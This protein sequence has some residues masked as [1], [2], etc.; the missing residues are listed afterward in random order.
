[1]KILERF[2]NTVNRATLFIAAVLFIIMLSCSIL[3]V[4]FRYFLNMSLAWTEECARYLF[5]YVVLLGSSV[6]V[7]ND[8]HVIVDLLVSK[9]TGTAKNVAKGFS[10][11]CMI[12]FFMATIRYGLQAMSRAA[13]QVSPVTR[14]NL[15]IVYFALPLSSFLMLIYSIEGLL[16]QILRNVPDDNEIE[17]EKGAVK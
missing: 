16:K 4:I 9:L 6:L 7:K 2:N 10:Y 14:T 1:M 15:G 3:Q 17:I 13:L 8:A 5:I 11:I 12:V